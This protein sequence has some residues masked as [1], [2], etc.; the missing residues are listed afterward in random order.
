VGG[1]LDFL[2]LGT[3]AACTGGNLANFGSGRLLRV[4]SGQLLWGVASI[5][6]IVIPILHLAHAFTW[7]IFA[8]V[9]GGAIIGA[10]VGRLL[11]RSRFDFAIS[12][13]L[14]VVGVGLLVQS[15]IEN[16]IF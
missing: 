4:R 11:R 1:Y 7:E 12:L 16:D 15:L 9:I 3:V 10:I 8:A 2:F 14:I 5:S 6:L 13:S